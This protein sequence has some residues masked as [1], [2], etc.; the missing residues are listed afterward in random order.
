RKVG[1]IRAPLAHGP[2]FPLQFLGFASGEPCGI[3]AAIPCAFR[4]KAF[5]RIKGLAIPKYSIF[6]LR[7]FTE[8]YRKLLTQNKL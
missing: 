7:F 3:S 6:A 1:R 5:F 2:G 8:N 4:G